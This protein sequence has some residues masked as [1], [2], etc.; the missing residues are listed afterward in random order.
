[1]QEQNILMGHGSGGKLSRMLVEEIFLKYFTN[2]Y[3][4]VLN[5][6]SIV[7]T[8]SHSSFTTDS[9]VIDPIFF[10]GGDIGKLAVCGTINDLLV[11]GSIPKYL[12]AAFIVEEGL[13]ISVLKKIV[14]SMAQTAKSTNV[15]IV[16]G[17]TKVVAKGQ[18]DKIYINTTGIGE[19]IQHASH[20]WKTPDLMEGDKI[21]VSGFLGDHAMAVLAARNNISFETELVSDVA[22]LSKLIL[23]LIKEFGNEIRFMRDITRG[24]LASVLNELCQKQ[25]FGIE[26]IESKIPMRQEVLGICEI[27][28]YDPLHLANEG[29]IVLAI[30]KKAADKILNTMRKLPYGQNAEI[31]GELKSGIKEKVVLKSVAGGSRIVEMLSGEMLPRIC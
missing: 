16:T 15:I 11:S 4:N 24:G 20:L 14:E 25:N 10:P 31:I 21:I 18:C 26:L 9:Y 8:T 6:S 5:D 23:P 28:G 12:S 3:L 2:P 7:E 17:D 30:T 22:P 27:F 29:K 19:G 1:M 13:P